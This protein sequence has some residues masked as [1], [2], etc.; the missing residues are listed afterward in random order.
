MNLKSFDK[1]QISCERLPSIMSVIRLQIGK[2][3]E[4]DSEQSIY[5]RLTDDKFIKA[6][7]SYDAYLLYGKQEN[8]LMDP[9]A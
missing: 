1:M 9:N 6:L 8:Y 2:E 3:T 4:G 5:Q 7:S